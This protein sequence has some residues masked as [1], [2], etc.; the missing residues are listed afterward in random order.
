MLA[1]FS[2]SKRADGAETWLSGSRLAASTIQG[3]PYWRVRMPVCSCCS[4]G[5]FMAQLPVNRE[6]LSQLSQIHALHV[7][8]FL[9]CFFQQRLNRLLPSAP[10]HKRGRKKEKGGAVALTAANFYHISLF[11]FQP[12]L[13]SESVSV[14]VRRQRWAGDGARPVKVKRQRLPALSASLF[15]SVCAAVCVRTR[16]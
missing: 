2:C 9:F 4:C 5:R 16:S 8:L 7:L 12:K 11:A 13:R 1:R 15:A 3:Y 6:M 14:L 10:R